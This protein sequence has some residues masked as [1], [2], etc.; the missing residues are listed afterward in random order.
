M[1]EVLC[2]VCNTEPKKYKCPTCSLPYCSIAC[3]KEHKP[4]HANDEPRP[5]TSAPAPPEIPQPPPPKPPPKYLRKKTDFSLVAK[6]PRYQELIKAHP[7]LLAS[8]QRI[9]AATIEPDPDDQRRSR[10]GGRGGRYRGRGR[11]GREER[12]T[13]KKGDADAMKLLKGVR[14]GAG[15][16]EEQEA[17][18]EFVRLVEE[19][20]GE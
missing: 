10:R 8:L 3:F 1:A 6:N 19:T 18:A 5:S 11:G 12:W 4:I 14:E 7:T 9:F 16:S 17:V 15:T 20:V 2:G 13:P